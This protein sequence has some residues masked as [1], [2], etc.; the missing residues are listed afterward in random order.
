M[1]MM[2]RTRGDCRAFH[3]PLP[4]PSDGKSQ[5]RVTLFE[6][7]PYT[8]RNLTKLLE[9]RARLLNFIARTT[10]RRSVFGDIPL[11]NDA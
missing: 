2:S 9:T 1:P 10:L 7:M 5:A 3:P 8:D 4:Y 11:V 6:E